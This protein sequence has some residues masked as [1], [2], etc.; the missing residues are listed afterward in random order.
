MFPFWHDV[1]APVLEAAAARRIVEVG[2][3]RGEHTELMLERLGPDAELH[4]IDPHPE[5]DPDEHMQRFPGRYV[6]H[7]SLSVDVLGALPAMD[8]ALLDGDH[9]WYTV[10]TELQLL[11]RVARA[12]AAPLP[13]CILHDVDWPYGRRDLYYDPSNIPEEHRRPWRRAGMRPDRPELMPGGGGLNP[14]LA[15]AEVE[16]GP[17]NGVMTAIEDFVAQH[18]RPLRLVHLPLYFGLAILVEHERLDTHP[19]LAAELDRLE[20][21]DGQATLIRL[22]ETIRLDAAI[23]DQVL[24]KQRDDRIDHLSTRYLEAIKA[25]IV[26]DFHVEIEARLQHLADAAA[27]GVSP[28]DEVLQDPVRHGADVVGRI[29]RRH[30][31]GQPSEAPDARAARL[32]HDVGLD[33]QGFATAGRVGLDH[34]Q[35]CLDGVWATGVTGDLAVCGAGFGAP[36]ILMAAYLQARE[37]EPRRRLR[38]RLWVADR[39]RRDDGHSDLNR[40][41]DALARFEVLDDC[42]KL[43]QGDPADTL[44]DITA[45]QLALV[46]LGPGLGRD[47]RVALER[48]YPR[49]AHGG[50]VIVEDALDPPMR[51]AL[52][53]YRSTHGIGA[54][55]ERVGNGSVHW[56]K[57]EAL[58]EPSGADT[59]RAAGTSRA[60]LAP[61]AGFLPLDL[62]VVIV[63]HNMRREAERSLLALSRRHQEGIEDLRYEVVVVENGSDAEQRLGEDAVRSFGREFRYLDLGRE[64]TTSPVPALNRGIATARGRALAVMIDGAHVVTPRVLHYGMVGLA[65]YAPAVVAA[66]AWYVGPGQQGDVMRGGYDQE[67]EDQLFEQIA[68]PS[69]GYR[70]F[71]IGHF[72][73]DRDWF[74]GLWES[75]CLFVGRE[76]LEQVGGFD[77]GFAMPGGGYTNLDLYERLASSPGLRVVSIIGEGSFH[78]VHGGTTTN[79]PD[80]LE[81]RARVR[82]YAEH[83]AELRGRPFMG[84]EKPIHYVGGFHVDAARRSRARRMTATAFDVE[85]R[86][87]GTDGP[88][89]PPALPVPDDLRDSFTNA[90]YRSLA[91]QQTRWIGHPVA[92]APTDL[93]AYQELLSDVRP[94]WVVTTGGGDGGRALFLATICDL[95]GHGQVLAVAPGVKPGR[96]EHPRLAYLTGVAHEAAVVDE[97]RQVLG[98]DARVVVILGTRGPRDRTRREFE[99]YAPMVPVGS[100]VVIEHTA[101]NGFPVDASFGP[102]P[103]EALRRIMNVHGEFSADSAREAHA[104]TLNPGGFL[105]RV[106]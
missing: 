40:T 36:A 49:L 20:G 79:L 33:R 72:V 105:R 92:N 2:A 21:P 77:E 75:N 81:R 97:V 57:A 11:A 89:L 76:L 63:I 7:R 27:R 22:G 87:E 16:G 102:G 41:R 101:L 64:A 68:W 23:F 47:A 96:A 98:P 48:L 91:W 74:D 66:Q 73:G 14:T 53:S 28:R 80:P 24:L 60:P 52:T 25:G 29:E 8:A 69:D 59:V 13:I 58:G 106:T 6:F 10:F 50:I 90:Y 103:H 55:L 35:E 56:V 26:N 54:V 45:D 44:P 46:Y 95:L 37:A 70:L 94:D 61:P 34:L 19:A 42:T 71:E 104:L 83:F 32:V 3:L 38:R 1:V 93:F 5:F 43:L 86:L 88:A 12:G 99:A 4:V 65:A 84:P 51:D 30:R 78:Q 39:F 9:N 100:Y 17:R 67:H 15:N 18:D 82:S 85:P 31:S 62:S